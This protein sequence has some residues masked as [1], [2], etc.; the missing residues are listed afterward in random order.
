[1]TFSTREIAARRERASERALAQA[2][3][4]SSPT[5]RGRPSTRR[6]GR[7]TCRARPRQRRMGGI[8]CGSLAGDSGQAQ[9]L[10][11]L[12]W[13]T[14]GLPDL[15]DGHGERLW[16]AV[17]TKYK[18]LLNC[19]AS[20][21]CLDMTPAA[22]LG[23]DQP[24]AMPRARR[25]RRHARATRRRRRRRDHRRARSA[26]ASPR[27]ERGDSGQAQV[28][29]CAP[30]ECDAWGR[31]LGEPPQRTPTCDPRNYLDRAPGARSATR[32]TPTSSIAPTRPGARSTA[33]AS[34][35]GPWRWATAASP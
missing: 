5:R 25:A 28:R 29:E 15:R 30:G 2:R 22:A 35:T 13:K 34:S 14:L 18:G 6:W 31:C 7:D 12:P 23:N 21:A 26:V 10:G 20:A 11:R 8:T 27:G 24:C 3:E 32:T 17:S 16:Y 9:R 33:T 19:A 1:M 4:A